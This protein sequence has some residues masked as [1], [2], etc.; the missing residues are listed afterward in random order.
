MKRDERGYAVGIVG[1]G[2][3]GEILVEVLEERGFPVRALRIMATS[4]RRQVFGGRERD[5]IAASPEAFEGLDI[6]LFAGTEGESGASRL[7]GWPAA[8]QGI[9]VIDNGGDFRMDPRVPL[10]VPEVNAEAM[11]GHQGFIANPNCSTIQMVAALAPLHR[12]AGLRRVVVSTYQAVSGTGRAGVRALQQQAQAAPAG[13][14]ADTGPYPHPIYGNVLPQVGSLK[15][16]CPG[17]YSE[18]IKMIEETRKIFG[19]PDLGVSAT[20]ARVP[21]QNGHSEAINAEFEREISVEEARRLLAGFPG[22]RVVD[23]PAASQYPTAREVS[24][25]DEVFV[26][27]IRKDP[28]RPNCLDLWCVADNVRKGAA[29]NAVQIAEKAVEMGLL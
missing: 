19:C 21:V 28:S 9:L 29:L 15:E 14:E 24:G 7:Y 6:A 11:R 4:A 27:R 23:D 25:R 16:H 13:G 3:V 17:Y 1:A 5:V 2:M 26:G 8:E 22:I 20:C 10:I 18:E 12:A